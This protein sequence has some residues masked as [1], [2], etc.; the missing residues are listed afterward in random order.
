MSSRHPIRRIEVLA[1]VAIGGFAGSNLR[2]VVDLLVGGLAGTLLVNAVGSFA[3]GAVL[4]EALRSDVLAA[5]T[6]TVVGTG[7]LSSFTTYSTFALQSAQAGPAL[8]VG[9]VVA[10]Y[11]LGFAGVAASKSVVEAIEGR[12]S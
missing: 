6:R 11:A 10:T 2:Y 4:Y 3:L 12:W 1:L 5:E 9:N 7:F 8:L